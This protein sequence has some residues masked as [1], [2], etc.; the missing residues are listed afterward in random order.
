VEFGD[1]R[2]F[3]FR[4]VAGDQDEFVPRWSSIDPFPMDQ[5][6]VV[7]GNHIEIVKPDS[8]TSL[9]VQVL[10][11][12]IAGDAAPNGPWSAARIAVESRDFHL[13]I[14][15][16]W[17]N[18][19]KLDESALVQ[20]ALALEGVGRQADAVQL[21]ESARH[22]GKTDAL[23]VLAGRLKR[24]WIVDHI[25]EDARLSRQLYDE[26]YQLSVAAGNHSQAFY[27]GINVA[28]MDLIFGSNLD[29]AMARASLVLEHC[30]TANRDLWC[31][32]TRGEALL[33]LGR[34]EEAIAAYR[35]AV[36][37]NPTPRQLRSMYQ[38]AVVVAR[39]AG[40][41]AAERS[42]ESIFKG[43]GP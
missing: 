33:V 38:Q 12:E 10:L 39:H 4:V 3:A 23:G 31:M 13:A 32:A 25:E 37:Q 35:D 36:R 30:A 1:R 26:A 28:F 6:D 43:S 2:P 42:L 22:K 20:L 17:P 9:S 41:E 21:L 29:A 18:R 11:R 15:Q 8:D 16:F 14:D 34:T 24:R 19:D 40:D 5:R 27:H 7:P